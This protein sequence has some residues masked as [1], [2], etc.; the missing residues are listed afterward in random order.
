[1]NLSSILLTSIQLDT[2]ILLSCFERYHQNVFTLQLTLRRWKERK[3]KLLSA[4]KQLKS[5]KQ[6]KLRKELL[7]E[8][9]PKPP[10]SPTPASPSPKAR[11][12]LFE[13][14]G[15]KKQLG[16]DDSRPVVTFVPQNDEAVDRS[17]DEM[18][19]PVG[20]SITIPENSEGEEEL[21][22][23]PIAQI[24]TEITHWTEVVNELNQDYRDL[25]EQTLD[26]FHHFMKS[27]RLLVL[28]SVVQY[29]SKQ[30]SLFHIPL[31]FHQLEVCRSF[32]QVWED[33]LSSLLEMNLPSDD[34]VLR[35]FAQLSQH[36]F[37]HKFGLIQHVP[38][39]SD[40]SISLPDGVTGESMRERLGDEQDVQIRPIVS[41]IDDERGEDD[42][43]H[44]L[45]VSAGEIV[46]I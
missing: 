32:N 35:P 25:S 4:A 10:S 30:V 8:S 20:E 16:E 46:E 6:E 45:C 28:E 17:G 37:I 42:D 23:S 33:T 36:S 15:Q 40:M 26:E 44:P 13:R 3:S 34:L 7:E 39:A 19:P 2:D 12:S 1:L 18:D 43:H 9:S 41:F 27:K 14:W 11:S 24:D 22:N 5:K 38:A 29:A 31:S 21:P